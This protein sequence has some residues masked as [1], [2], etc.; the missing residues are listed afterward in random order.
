MDAFLLGITANAT[1]NPQL[2]VI[3]DKDAD[4]NGNASSKFGYQGSKKNKLGIKGVEIG[5]RRKAG[6]CSRIKGYTR[7]TAND[8]QRRAR[9]DIDTRADTMCAGSTFELHE[10]TGKLVDVSGFHDSLETMKDIEV[11]TA[12]TAIDLKGETIIGVFNEAL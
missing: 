8:F 12:I 2:L 1:I 5:Q 6:K 11:V 3:T 4:D 7:N 10:S 9:V